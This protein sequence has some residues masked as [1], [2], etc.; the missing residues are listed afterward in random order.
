MN[1]TNDQLLRANSQKEPQTPPV[2]IGKY[3]ESEYHE[4]EEEKEAEHFREQVDKEK[5]K[6]HL[7]LRKT[8]KAMYKDLKMAKLES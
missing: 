3:Q 8:L 4:E 5:K 1:D 6:I 7:K 2:I